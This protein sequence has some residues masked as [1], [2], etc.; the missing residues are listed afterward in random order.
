[1]DTLIRVSAMAEHHPAIVE[2]D[3]DPVMVTPYGAVVVDAR[4][5]VRAPAPPPRFA[6][7]PG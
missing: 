7:M 6:G 4:V 1:V 3:C 5:R 2:L